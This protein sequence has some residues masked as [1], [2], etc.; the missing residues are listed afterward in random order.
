MS[1]LVERI[2]DSPLMDDLDE[3]AAEA[4]RVSGGDPMVAVKALI[5]G[6]RNLQEAFAER[7]SAGYVRRGGELGKRRRTTSVSVAIPIED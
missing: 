3:A 7:I 4:V 5:L 6:Q 2:T 1:K